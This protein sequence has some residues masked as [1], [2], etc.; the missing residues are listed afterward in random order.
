MPPANDL[1]GRTFERLTVLGQA[2]KRNGN[3]NL[4]WRV[5][6]SCKARTV[7][8][9]FGM[10][11]LAGRTTSCGCRHDEVAGQRARQMTRHGHA[12]NWNG[13]QASRTYTAWSAMWGRCTNPKNLN[14]QYYGAKGVCVAKRWCQF[15]NFLTDMGE[16]PPGYEIERKDPFGNYTP[17]N[18]IWTTAAMQARN[19]RKT[20][21]LK[22]NGVSLPIVAW[23]ER[24]GI[25]ASTLRERIKREWSPIDVLTTPWQKRQGVEKRLLKHNDISLPIVAWAKCLGIPAPTLHKRIKLGWTTIDVLTKPIDLKKQKAARSRRWRRPSSR[26][27]R[28]G[29]VT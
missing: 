18:C 21:R 29:Q 2:P 22:Y 5:Q 23:A 27:A 12:S 9:V 15:E 28:R 25:P 13:K 16:C 10:D 4:R 1:T 8:T 24:I 20:Q 26:G 6:C 14:Y 7:K 17:K 3:S 19:K 11:L